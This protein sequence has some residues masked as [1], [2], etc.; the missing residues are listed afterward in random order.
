MFI[1][2]SFAMAAETRVSA[3]ATA[4]VSASNNPF[5][6]TQNHA[7]AMLAEL[8][9]HPV[10]TN[11]TETTAV[12]LSGTLGHRRY[13]NDYGSYVFGSGLLSGS[14]RQNERLSLRG[15]LHYRQEVS[16]DTVED[17]S[18]AIDPDSVRRSF[19]ASGTA[20]WQIS[21]LSSLTPSFNAERVSYDRTDE[22]T[23]YDR[24]G[25]AL[26][27]NR[28]LSPY[29]SVGIGAGVTLFKFR[30]TPDTDIQFAE[31][32]VD[33]KFSEVLAIE[34]SLGAQRVTFTEFD[35]IELE[36]KAKLLLQGDVQFCRRG[37]ATNICLTGAV[38]SEPSGL[39]SIERRYSSGLSYGLRLAE[40]SNISIAANYQ[41]SS[42][43]SLLGNEPIEYLQAS[44]SFDRR[45]TKALTFDTFLRY[46]HRAGIETAGS[47]QAGVNLRLMVGRN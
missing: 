43:L 4:G 28:R 46:R 39:G 2:P 21:E 14:S 32:T 18:G 23:R 17:V 29:T 11:K 38:S 12:E 45:I 15:A 19:G 34:G 47:A 22:L 44:A 5:L 24:L 8:S 40:F 16:T 35:G 3:T 36:R 7:A 31:A 26:G 41:R 20:A 9:L 33:H 25:G 27:Y 1:L 42:G 30:D 10:L 13:S 6:S 37:A